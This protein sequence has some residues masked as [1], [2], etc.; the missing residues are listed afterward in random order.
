[1]RIR[2]AFTDDDT[3][4]DE[5]PTLIAAVDEYTENVWGHIP[6]FYANTL[7]EYV[8]VREVNVHL[9]DEV[10]RTLFEVSTASI[11]VEAP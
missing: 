11:T 6:D 4:P 1:M 9:P 5:M 8:G 10:V 3:S 7:A 2:L